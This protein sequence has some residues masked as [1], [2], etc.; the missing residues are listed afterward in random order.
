VLRYTDRFGQ[1]Q[2][3][4]TP[5]LPIDPLGTAEGVAMFPDANVDP[6]AGG[7]RD[8]SLQVAFEGLYLPTA[9]AGAPV[10][11]RSAHPAEREPQLMLIPYRGDLGLDDGVPRSVLRLDPAQLEAGALA[12]AGEPEFLAP[13]ESMTLEDG[14]AVEFVGTQRWITVSVRHDPGQPVALVGIGLLL[15]GLVGSLVGRR[16]RVWFRVTPDPAGRGSLV[17]AGG[18]PRSDYP[19]FAAEFT[20]LVAA[21]PVTPVPEP[22]LSPAGRST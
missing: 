21:L 7:Q 10:L 9:P 2:T 20:Q 18:L 8:R 1:S 12:Q 11:A 16:R 5:F 13:G 4:T 19:G 3:T 22:E 15:A 6:A 17:E 14:T